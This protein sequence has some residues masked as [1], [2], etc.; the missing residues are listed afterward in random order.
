MPLLV[1]K[2]GNGP[3]YFLRESFPHYVLHLP[4]AV[5]NDIVAETDYLLIVRLSGHTNGQGVEESR[6]AVQIP[7]TGE[8]LRGN[9]YRLINA[10]GKVPAQLVE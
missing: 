5:F 9:L 4:F 2:Y 6:L 7:L 1:R 10:G 8:D 3:G